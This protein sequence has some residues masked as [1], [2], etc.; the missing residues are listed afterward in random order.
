MSNM[1]TDLQSQL[2]KIVNAS[3]RMTKLGVSTQSEYVQEA[4]LYGSNNYFDMDE[5]YVKAGN[6]IAEMLEAEDAVVT[7]CAS[8]GI[9]FTIAGLVCGSNHRLIENLHIEKDDIKKR[10]VIIPKGHS[11]DYGVPVHTMIELG[12]G[13]VVEAGNANKVTKLDVESYINENT[14]ALFYVKSHHAVQKNMV[15]IK[16]MV[17]LSK[18]HQIPLIIDAAAEEDFKTYYQQGADFVVYSGAKALCGPSSGFVLCRNKEHSSNL[19]KQYY[20]IGRSM[21][22]GKENIFGLVATG[23][24]SATSSRR[25]GRGSPP[26]PC[27]RAYRCASVSRIPGVLRSRQRAPYAPL[28]RPPRLQQAARPS[29]NPREPRA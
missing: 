26:Q 20:G 4:I 15:S 13:K 5:L 10:E 24:K 19:R 22:I 7:S 1:K 2:R 25:R 21:K 14:I 29:S 11:V 27:A 16:E 3:G 6:Y 12:G 9:V 18:K 23:G 8:S 17:E 28:P